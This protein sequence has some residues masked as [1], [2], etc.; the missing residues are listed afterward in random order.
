MEPRRSISSGQPKT[1]MLVTRTNAGKHSVMPSSHMTTELTGMEKGLSCHC[2]PPLTDPV[3]PCQHIHGLAARNMRH[4]AYYF[5]SSSLSA[6][7]TW[8]AASAD[9]SEWPTREIV[10][11]RGRASP[12]LNKVDSSVDVRCCQ[13]AA[14]CAARAREVC[15]EQSLFVI[16]LAHIL[17]AAFTVPSAA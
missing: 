11:K 17:S 14:R 3:P 10:E 16:P 15:R 8:Y 6:I 1:L 9:I 12:L 7:E 4:L 2:H 5:V 13:S